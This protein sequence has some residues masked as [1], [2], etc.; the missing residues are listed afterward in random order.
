M[1]RWKMALAGGLAALGI[2]GTASAGPDPARVAAAAEL[3]AAM[4]GAGQVQASIGQLR[5]ALAKDMGERAPEK[6]KEF[7]DYLGK[8]AGAE[9]A[10]VKALLAGIEEQATAFYAER[11]TAEELKAV[12][13]FQGSAAGRKF[14]ELTPQLAA[15]VGPRLMEFQKKLIEDLQ[16]ATNQPM[17]PAKAPEAPK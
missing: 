12:A 4:G 7:A 13:A 6:A 3:I 9:S 17:W 14:Q 2:A 5:E 15:I 8:E 1:T 10:R 11:F 16:V